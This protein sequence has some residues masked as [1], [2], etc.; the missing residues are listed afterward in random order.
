MS[1]KFLLYF[2][3]WQLSTFVLAGPIFLLEQFGLSAVPNLIIAQCIG[4]LIFYP[5]DK[6]IFKSRSEKS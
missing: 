4:C 5:I 2:G 6:Y 1:K 3:R